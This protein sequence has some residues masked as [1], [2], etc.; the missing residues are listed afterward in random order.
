[1]NW[2]NKLKTKASRTVETPPEEPPEIKKVEKPAKKV[3]EVKPD[4]EPN[5]NKEYDFDPAKTYLVVGGKVKQISSKSKYLLDM[6]II[7]EEN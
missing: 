6:L 2:R 3:E 7:K 4:P 1:M 5:I